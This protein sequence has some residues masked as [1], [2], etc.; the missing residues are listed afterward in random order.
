MQRIPDVTDSVAI[1]AAHTLRI[2]IETARSTNQDAIKQALVRA[3]P[4][5]D[6]FQPSYMRKR[7]Y[8]SCLTLAAVEHE[9]GD[10]LWLCQL[11]KRPIAADQCPLL[12][13]PSR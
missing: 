7:T 3:I 8:A 1:Y 11:Y 9:R 12:L 5:P 4:S 10:L 6:L 13:L 2:A